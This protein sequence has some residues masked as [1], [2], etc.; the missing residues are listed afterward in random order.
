[1]LRVFVIGAGLALSSFAEGLAGKWTATVATP[2]G[3]TQE[4]TYV[5]QVTDGKI[6][7]SVTVP[8]GDA[9][10]TEGEVTGEDV[11]F[12]VTAEMNG[13]ERK[14][15]HKGKLSGDK[16]EMKIDFGGREIPVTAKRA[17]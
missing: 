4:A 3:S 7:G 13:Q 17:S 16:L 5:F 15:T 6:K 12:V 2:D 1:M 8:T 10:I 11:T 14:F 9:P